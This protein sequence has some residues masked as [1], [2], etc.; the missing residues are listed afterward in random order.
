[1]PSRTKVE[2]GILVSALNRRN[3]AICSWFKYSAYFSLF[4]TTASYNRFA[5]QE[6]RTDSCT[7]SFVQ[8]IFTTYAVSA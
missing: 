2:A 6:S 7:C 4:S 5:S 1:M 3:S 8:F